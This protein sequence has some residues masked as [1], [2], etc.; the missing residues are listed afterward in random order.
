MNKLLYNQP[1]TKQTEL[2]QCGEIITNEHLYYCIM[3]NEGNIRNEKYEQIFNGSITE[4]KIII[5]I[6]EENMKKHLKSP[7]AQA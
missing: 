5:N 6:L 2:C 3:L 7:S 4:Q 1:G